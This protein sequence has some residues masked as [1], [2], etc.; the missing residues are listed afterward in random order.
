MSRACRV[1]ELPLELLPTTLSQVLAHT[2]S[3]HD[4]SRSPSNRLGF[5]M[6]RRYALFWRHPK[7]LT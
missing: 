6:R 4:P 7:I 1:V 3:T 2:S 5:L